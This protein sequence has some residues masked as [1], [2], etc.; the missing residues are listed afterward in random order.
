[1]P[2]PASDVRLRLLRLLDER[3]GLTVSEAARRLGV[4]PSTA[5]Y[6]ACLLQSQGLV[7]RQAWGAR[8][9]L[10]PAA[11]PAAE[12]TR[13]LTQRGRATEVLEET[14]RTPRAT[15]DDLAERLRM[16]RSG[17]HWHLARL[18]RQGLLA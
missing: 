7:R 2:R 13:I 9:F 4:S 1:M 12:R 16:T 18:R 11:T 14:R 6:H 3:P 10:F 8:S 17:V 5:K 15:L